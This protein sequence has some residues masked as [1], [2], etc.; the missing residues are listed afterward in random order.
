MIELIPGKLY[1][2]V[3]GEMIAWP[4]PYNLNS[5]H[6]GKEELLFFVKTINGSYPNGSYYEYATFLIK[7]KTCRIYLSN[8]FDKLEML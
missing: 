7:G 5:F 6:V 2:I 4:V 8:M 3:K 1:K